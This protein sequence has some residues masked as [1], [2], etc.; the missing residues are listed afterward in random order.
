MYI[1][2][3]IYGDGGNS[4]VIHTFPLSGSLNRQIC[5]FAFGY[6]QIC[7]AYAP[8]NSH[9]PGTLYD[10]PTLRRKKEDNNKI[11]MVL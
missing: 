6:T 9:I 4:A 7:S 1:M 8:Q 5:G 3:S 2:Y 11:L 10:V